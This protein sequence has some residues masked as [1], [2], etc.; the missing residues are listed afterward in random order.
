M[1]SFRC[2]ATNN[3]WSLF[4]MV[5]VAYI[6]YVFYYLAALFRCRES[7]LF[8]HILLRCM[9]LPRPSTINQ[10]SMQK[11]HGRRWWHSITPTHISSV[12]KNNICFNNYINFSYSACVNNHCA[13]LHKLH[14][15]KTNENLTI[16]RVGVQVRVLTHRSIQGLKTA[17]IT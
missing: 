8:Y 2:L 3:S 9:L 1:A 15:L 5:G 4:H 17:Y 10:T 6:P 13:H 11:K 7:V 16:C 14:E 12:P